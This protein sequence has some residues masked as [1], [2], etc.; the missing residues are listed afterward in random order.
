MRRRQWRRLLMLLG[1]V[2][3]I[4][5]TATAVSAH[6]QLKTADPADKATVTD[7]PAQVTLTFTEETSATQSNGSVVDASGTTVSTGFKVDLN[8]RTK[9]T[10]ALKPNLP[11]GT[12]TVKFHTLTEDDNAV[13]DG[14]TTFTVQ[15]A[16]SA[17]TTTG[18]AAVS[19]TSAAGSASPAAAATTATGSATATRAATAT[20]APTVAATATRPASSVVAT[21]TG[22]GTT[23]TSPTTLPQ[24]GKNASGSMLPWLMLVIIVGA[25]AV[26]IGT[27]FRTRRR[28]S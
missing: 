17:T 5:L 7:A 25:G 28:R 16:A 2:A 15:A 21:G 14:T 8:E 6:A 4:C 3:L 19:S 11:N 10:I 27:A 24:T 26:A 12:Y 13:V 9:M 1:I 20:T 22:G 18:T 23:A